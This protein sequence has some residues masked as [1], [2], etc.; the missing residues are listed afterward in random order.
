MAKSR[1][2]DLDLAP[3]GPAVTRGPGVTLPPPPS[4]RAPSPPMGTTAAR[5]PSRP[6]G[7]GGRRMGAAAA[8]E[9]FEAFPAG[10]SAFARWLQD[11]GLASPGERRTAE[12]WADLLAEFAARPIYGHRRGRAGGNHS[13]NPQ[14]LR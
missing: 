5:R 11:A 6:L 9:A 4:K 1:T 12:G 8:G 2:P 13:P 14:H 7:T 10:G 3:A